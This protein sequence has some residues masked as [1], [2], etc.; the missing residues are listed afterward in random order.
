MWYNGEEAAP[1]TMQLTVHPYRTRQD[2]WAFNHNHN[3]TV[4]ELLMN[5][6]ELVIDAYYKAL[7]GQDPK[8]GDRITF[9]LSTEP[10]TVMESVTT[11]TYSG[12]D[13]NGSHFVDQKTGMPLWLCPWLQGFFG[14]VPHTIYVLPSVFHGEPQGD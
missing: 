13:E 4:G 6:T 14:H 5:G 1:L 11:L 8:Q 9:L 12:G 2:V 3:N 10:I 7:T